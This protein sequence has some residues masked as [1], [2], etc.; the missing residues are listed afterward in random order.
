M[1]I[2]YMKKPS[3]AVACFVP[4][5]AKDLSAPLYRMFNSTVK[6]KFILE[7]TTKAQRGVDIVLLFL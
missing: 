2:G 6:V 3:V 4:G 7:Q 5:R 1:I